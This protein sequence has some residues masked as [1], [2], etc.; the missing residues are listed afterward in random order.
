MDDSVLKKPL[1]TGQKWTVE[2]LLWRRHWSENMFSFATTRDP[3]FDFTPGQFARLGIPD[4]SGGIIWRP[5]S[6]VSSDKEP[7]LEFLSVVVPEG[8]F[9]TRLVRMQ[10]NDPIYI[11]KVSYGFLTPQR[12]ADGRDLWMLASGTG[13]G[14]YVSILRANKVW[15]QYANIVVVHSVRRANELAY[16]TEMETLAGSNGAGAARLR[17]IPVVTRESCPGALGERIPKLIEGG[18]L[19][20]AAGL[21]LDVE[22]SRLMICGNPD[23]A[24]DLRHLLTERGFRVGR[25]AEPGQ[26]AFENYWDPAPPSAAAQG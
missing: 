22:H 17:Y 23:M 18:E 21:P 25:R 6:M 13:L 1:Q 7:Q 3:A 26:L 24:A 9:T 14:P 8:A 12:F 4:D 19:M 20:A 5:H 16:Q 15:R 10:P 11:E 2:R